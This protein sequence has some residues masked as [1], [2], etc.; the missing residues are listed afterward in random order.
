VGFRQETHNKTADVKHD[1]NRLGNQ[2]F[3]FK[4]L[5]DAHMPVTHEEG[6]RYPLKPPL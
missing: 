2:E 3:G 4:V 5:M 1:Y 6:D